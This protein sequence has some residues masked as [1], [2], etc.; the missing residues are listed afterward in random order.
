MQMVVRIKI[1]K[2]DARASQRP[3]P[4]YFKFLEEVLAANEGGNGYLVGK[5]ISFADV[6]LLNLLRGYRGS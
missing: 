1:A 5:K 6:A 2:A 3:L 4:K